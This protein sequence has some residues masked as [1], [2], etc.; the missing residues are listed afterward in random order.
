[1]DKKIKEV[2]DQL[3]KTVDTYW[4]VGAEVGE[5]LNNFIKEKNI[6]SVFEIGTSNGYS[7]LW[8]ADALKETGGHLYTIESHKKKRFYLAQ[9]NFKNAEVT[10]IVTQILGHAP[11]HIPEEPRYFDLSLFDATKHQHIDFFKTMAP[12]IKENGFIITDNIISHEK[13]LKKYIEFVNS[14]EDWISEIK[15]IGKGIMISQYVPQA[16]SEL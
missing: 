15:D 12:R 14:Q 4:N 8:I 13:E 3:E 1:M 7:G 16:S 5:F 9:D 2:L 11:E 6:K 10:D